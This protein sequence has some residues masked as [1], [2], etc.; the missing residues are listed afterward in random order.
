MDDAKR[1]ATSTRAW[2]QMHFCVVLWGFTAILGK[3]ITL[4]ALPLV[5]L[6]MIVVTAALMAFPGFWRG[7]LGMKPKLVLV[8]TGIGVLVA[9]HWLSFYSSIKLANASVAATCMALTPVFVAL[10]EPLMVRRRFDVREL[11][12]GIATV[13]GVALVVGGTPAGMRVGIAVGILAA[14]FGALFSILNKRFVQHGPAFTVTGL[15]MAAGAV[16]LSF[17]SPFVVPSR[18]DL[19]LLLVLAIGCTLVPFALWLV[20]LRHLST[21]SASLAVNMEPVYSIVLAI[22]LLGEQREL[23]PGFYAGVAIILTAVFGHPWL[24]GT[25][26]ESKGPGMY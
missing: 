26:P 6:R 22:V 9:A 23:T 1:P 17:V 14:F 12:F 11:F 21:F 15:E 7:L 18:Q 16:G 19:I 13:P 25:A 20:A 4:P 3:L 10:A 24:T 2:L 8:Y 5:W